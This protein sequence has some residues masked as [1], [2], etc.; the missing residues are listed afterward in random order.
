MDKNIK[1]FITLL[2]P[3]GEYLKTDM[4][5][6]VLLSASK[7]SAA[8]L[9]KEQNELFPIF[10]LIDDKDSSVGAEVLKRISS[11][12]N[13]FFTHDLD[14]SENENIEQ[15]IK[16]SV[17]A[18]LFGL[19]V[20][21][22]YIKDDMSIGIAHIERDFISIKDNKP[23]L[24]VG[25]NDYE[26]RSPRFILLRQKPVLIKLIWC[27]YAKH[28][29][30][31]HYLKFTEFLGVPPLIGN[32]SNG[33]EK[34]IE[35]MASALENL[36]S[37]GY[38][39]L[40]SNDVI[41]V[42]EGRGS[43]ADF[44]EFVRYCDAEIA[45]VIN[46][47]VLSS[48]TN[49][50]SGSLAM[51]RTHDENRKEILAGDM[52]FATRMTENIYASLGKKANLNI[53]IEK[54][55]DLLARAQTLQILHSMGYAMNVEDLAREFDLPAIKVANGKSQAN[56]TKNTKSKAIY[57]DEF[58]RAS[59]QKNTRKEECQISDIVGELLNECESFEEV[60]DKFLSLYP[61]LDLSEFENELG[62][63]IENATLKGL[64]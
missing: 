18:R 37:G 40:G 60:E 57:L 3:K 44:M 28:F 20:L 9:T 58:D 29:V 23:F 12:T 1:E 31:S 2:R 22:I 27:V 46:G 30:L 64:L 63:A 47:S 16:A 32:S 14:A 19:S 42:L 15:I 54:D 41:K 53:Q 21:E 48:N 25:K 62:K 45:K 24:R 4:T 26:V 36:K 38:A 55:S 34:V 51:S 59:D 8:L 11:L 6:Y 61:H 49:G 39:V 5:N 50:A 17:E 35:A 13:K 43:Q 52:K 33:D 10:S 56:L 7:I